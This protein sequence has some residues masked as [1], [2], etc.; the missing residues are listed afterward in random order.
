MI[1]A[2]LRIPEN[3]YLRGH[4]KFWEAGFDYFPMDDVVFDEGESAI[5]PTKQYIFGLHPHGMHCYHMG[6]FHTPRMGGKFYAKWPKF[7]TAGVVATVRCGNGP[8]G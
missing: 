7:R 6:L 5:S 4:A 3:G 2:K 1:D 8:M